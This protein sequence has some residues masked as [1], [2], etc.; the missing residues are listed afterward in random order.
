M[1]L[2]VA[3]LVRLRQAHAV[4]DDFLWHLAQRLVLFRSGC[5]EGSEQKRL[6]QRP[7]QQLLLLS[8]SAFLCVLRVLC[9]SVLRFL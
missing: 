5:R 3:H 2:G 6:K 1:D 9:G 4:D 8:L 7:E